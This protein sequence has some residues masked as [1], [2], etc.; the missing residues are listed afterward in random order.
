MLFST[1]KL[2][3]SLGSPMK[4]G[5]PLIAYTNVLHADGSL[6]GL[7]EMHHQTEALL[8]GSGV[9]HVLLRNGW[10]TENYIG[11]IPPTLEHGAFLG[12][13]G[14]GR[15]ASTTRADYAEAAATV[16]VSREDPSR[17]YP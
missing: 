2:M 12:S 7:N 16:L 10:Y 8:K 15:I 11:S 14:G 13:V 1:S 9:A 6:L 17:T 5:P 3:V 4:Q